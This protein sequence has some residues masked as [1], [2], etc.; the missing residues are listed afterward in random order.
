MRVSSI[1]VGLIIFVCACD[2]ENNF[3]I[4]DENYFVKFYGEEGDQ[5]GVDFIVNT[6][7]SVVMVGNTS[8]PGVLQQIYVVKVDPHGQVLWQRRIGLPDKNDIVKDVEL[9]PDGRIVIAG[10]TEMGTNNRDVYIRTLAQ[11]GSLL[12][13]A[14]HG[15]NNGSID[16]DEEVNSVSIVNGGGIFQPGFI[17]SGSTTFV[18]TNESTDLHDAM[19]LRFNN[20]LIRIR[21][22]GADP[23]WT[24]SRYGF[25]SDD[26]AVKAIEV[27]PSTIYVFGYSNRIIQTY[28]G[29]YNF[30]YYAYS[31]DGGIKLGENYFGKPS[32]DE[33]LHSVEIASNQPGVRYILSG[34]ATSSGSSKSAQSFVA[35]LT[36][37]LTF[38]STDILRERNPTDLGVNANDLLRVKVKGSFDDS[39]I[40]ISSDTRTVNQESNIAFVRL[41]S[42][43]VRDSEPLIFGGEGD[44]FSGSLAELPDGRI[45]ISGTMTIGGGNDKGQK[46]MVLMKLNPGGKLTE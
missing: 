34:T 30:W 13:S 31:G 38:S 16:T 37:Q 46:K 15:L 21:E 22:T 14:R 4:P 36:P 35:G 33:K 43:L 29:D 27:D 20:S 25:N 9:H 12:D 42:D 5:V 32:E 41:K 11:D 1:L 44:D 17:V 6:D 40:L 7:G 19:A 8:R 3:T 10:E 18:G 23:I 39:F 2:T 26:Y 28:N 24:A 45:L